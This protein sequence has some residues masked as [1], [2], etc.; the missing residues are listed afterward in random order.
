MTHVIFD[1]CLQSFFCLHCKDRLPVHL[2]MTVGE[3][4]TQARTYNEQHRYCQQLPCCVECGLGM[5]QHDKSELDSTV[6]K[7]C[8][9]SKC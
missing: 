1:L 2:P 3:L 5:H 6:C 9:G 7:D 4:E 8:A